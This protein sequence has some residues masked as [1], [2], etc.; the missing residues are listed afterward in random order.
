MQLFQSNENE[1]DLTIRYIAEIGEETVYRK[2]IR[3][4]INMPYCT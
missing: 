2:R 1:L 4:A 3:N